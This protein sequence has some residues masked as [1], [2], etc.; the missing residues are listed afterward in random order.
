MLFPDYLA[1]F[2]TE[3][4]RSLHRYLLFKLTKLYLSPISDIQPF[5]RGAN[6]SYSPIGPCSVKH[7]PLCIRFRV[8]ALSL[9]SKDSE[10]NPSLRPSVVKIANYC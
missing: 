10:F 3:A 4:Y 5:L 2:F 7:S 6:N 8:R 1:P 9:V